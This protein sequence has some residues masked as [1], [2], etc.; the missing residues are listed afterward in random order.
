MKTMRYTV[1]IYGKHAET[2]QEI[3]AT[4]KNKEEFAGGTGS[5]D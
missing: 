1:N 2:P 5:Q 4:G 3:Q